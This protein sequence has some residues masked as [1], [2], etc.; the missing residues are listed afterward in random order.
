MAVSN[1]RKSAFRRFGGLEPSP[2]PLPSAYFDHILDHTQVNFFLGQEDEKNNTFVTLMESDKDIILNVN[3]RK[4]GLHCYANQAG[5]SKF[6]ELPQ[7]VDYIK[8]YSTSAKL[9]FLSDKI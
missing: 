8:G 4:E 3:P 6:V 7:Y 9:M 1:S 2:S 5:T